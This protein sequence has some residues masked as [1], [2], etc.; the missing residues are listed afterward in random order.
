MM[1]PEKYEIFYPNVYSPQERSAIDRMLSGKMDMGY[2]ETEVAKSYQKNY[3]ELEIVLD[4]P[5]DQAGS[6][7]G[8]T[9]GNEALLGGVNEAI[10]AVLADGTMDDYVAQAN[11]RASGEKDEGLQDE[12]GQVQ[13]DDAAQAG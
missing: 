9:K 1:I 12:H 3:P 8:V 6:A 10:A 13:T 11:E 5:Y 7:I 2:I 4:V